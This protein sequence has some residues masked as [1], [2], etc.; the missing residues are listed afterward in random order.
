MNSTIASSS[1]LDNLRSA[2]AQSHL[3][4]EALPISASIMQPDV[5]SDEYLLYLA[6]MHDIVEDAENNIFPLLDT[7]IADLEERNKSNFLKSDL[8]FLG[9][10]EIAKRFPLSGSLPGNSIA[11]SLGI[12]YVVEGSS[13]GGRVILKNISNT[14]GYDGDHGA[15]YFTGYGGQTGSHWKRFLDMLQQ[16]EAENN[17]SEEIIAGADYA[18]NAIT[19]HFKNNTPQ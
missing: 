10:H 7:V 5:T 11:F 4:L 1:F 15:R 16:Y 14:L 19:R 3:N 12:M 9:Y 18:F 17:S 2:T 8:E 6:L 13:L